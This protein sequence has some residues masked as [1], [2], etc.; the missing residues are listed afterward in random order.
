MKTAQPAQTRVGW[1]VA[2]TAVASTAIVSVACSRIESC[3][4]CCPKA[5]GVRNLR[6]RVA[7]TLRSTSCSR[8]VDTPLT[9]PA[10]TDGRPP[11]NP[12]G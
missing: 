3:L 1:R 6:A 11:E 4:G 9:L 2:A 8:S 12:R 10:G 7:P 5:G